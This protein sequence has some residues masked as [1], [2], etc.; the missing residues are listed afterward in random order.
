LNAASVLGGSL[1]RSG[2]HWSIT[3]QLIQ[4]PTGYFIWAERYDRELKDVFEVRDEIARSIRQALRIELSPQEEKAIAHKQTQTL[5]PTTTIYGAV[6]FPISFAG[7][8]ID[9]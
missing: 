1:G 7:G 9:K 4:A 2:N 3:A 8:A 5:R 6:S